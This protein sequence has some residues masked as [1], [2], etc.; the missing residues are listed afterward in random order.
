MKKRGK[1]D[2]GEKSNH[3]L[4]FIAEDMSFPSRLNLPYGR[5]FLLRLL[6]LGQTISGCDVRS[7]TTDIFGIWFGQ[8]E[9]VVYLTYPF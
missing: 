1:R 5:F 4:S 9:K 6:L 7:D 2:D 8:E 3:P